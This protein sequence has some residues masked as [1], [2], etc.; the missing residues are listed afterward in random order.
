MNKLHLLIPTAFDLISSTLQYTSLN[1]VSASIYQMMRGG[2]IVTTFLF[3]IFFLKL[4]IKKYQVVGALLALSGCIIVG[5]NNI[6]YAE[7]T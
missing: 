6:I 1:F 7:K 4:K 5:A 3:S 2:T